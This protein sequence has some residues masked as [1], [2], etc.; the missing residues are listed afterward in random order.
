MG[1]FTF[2]FLNLFEVLIFISPKLSFES[3][4]GIDFFIHLLFPLH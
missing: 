2:E 1:D 4:E 3:E